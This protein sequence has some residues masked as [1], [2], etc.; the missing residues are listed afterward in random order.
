MSRQP[1][2]LGKLS[3]MYSFI[4]N[5]HTET[6]VSRCPRCEQ[7]MR[8]RKVPLFIHVDPM[9]PMILGYTCRYCPDCD[10][11]VAHQDEIEDLLARMF[12]ERD[13][14]VIGNDY[15]VM[16]TVER[17]LWREGMKAGKTVGELLENLHDFVEVSELEYDP[18]GWYPD[19]DAAAGKREA[20]RPEPPGPEQRRSRKRRDKRSGKRSKR[21]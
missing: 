16:G 12:A 15:L 11:L 17:A 2:R 8:Q 7:R 19:E 9:V 3:P 6:R 18:G 1:S 5:P 4:L 10:L 14:S 13:P 21:R 20:A